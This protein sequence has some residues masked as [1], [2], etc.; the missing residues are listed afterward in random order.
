MQGSVRVAYGSH[1]PVVMGSTPILASN[2]DPWCN[3]NTTVFGTVFLGSNPGG[4]TQ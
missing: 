2:F 3:G 1:N 4:S